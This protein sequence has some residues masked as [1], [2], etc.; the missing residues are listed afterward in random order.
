ML[1]RDLLARYKTSHRVCDKDV[2]PYYHRD[3]PL[4]SFRLAQWLYGVKGT[5]NS[6]AI[7]PIKKGFLPRVHGMWKD[8]TWKRKAEQQEQEIP[9][10][11]VSH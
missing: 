2:L 1:S 4:R 6:I 9:P 7:R 8:S 10:L 3:D 5:S 11:S